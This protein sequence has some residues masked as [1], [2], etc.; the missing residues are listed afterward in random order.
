MQNPRRAASCGPDVDSHLH[1]VTY[2]ISHQMRDDPLFDS[3]T[4]RRLFHAV[5]AGCEVSNWEVAHMNSN[6]VPVSAGKMLLASP[7]SLTMYQLANR[8]TGSTC[9]CRY[10]PRYEPRSI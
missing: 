6:A 5:R 9:R 10:V 3:T 4:I 2:V 1:Y 7:S 8:P